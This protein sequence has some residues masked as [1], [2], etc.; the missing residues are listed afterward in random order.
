MVEI[1]TEKG[2]GKEDAETI[3][4][5]MAKYP[6]FFVDVMMKDELGMELPDP[7]APYDHW[8][9]GLY[10][11]A[12]FMVCGSVPLIG[13]VII[14]PATDDKEILFGVSCAMT[15]LM[16]FL[17]GA[18]KS[19]FTAYTWYRSGFEVLGVGGSCAAAAYFIGW[20]IEVML[21]SMG[22]S[23][24]GHCPVNASLL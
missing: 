21:K 12:S 2:V 1:Y 7:D 16:L 3:V 15:A 6:S 24:E 22:V 23:I 19:R 11:F 8:I 9:S 13:Y 20:G 10:C 17:L 5:T 18:L 4:T 14:M